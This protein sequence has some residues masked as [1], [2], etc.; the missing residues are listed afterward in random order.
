M[1]ISTRSR[2]ICSTSRPTY[3]TSVNLVASTLMK[4]APASLARRREISVLPTPVGPIIR[5][6]FGSTSSRSFSSSCR[7]RHRLRNATAT[8][9][10]AS[11]CPMM[12]RS[13][14]ETISRGEKSVM[15]S[16]L[17]QGNVAIVVDAN[18]CGN[19]HGFAHDRLCI[20]RP[21]EQS[22]R[23][24][25][26]VIAARAYAHNAALGLEDVA[27][28][29]ENKR[30]LGIRHDH[31]GLQP[32]QIAIGTP[33]LGELDGGAGELPGILLELG[34]K[35]LEQGESIGGSA[36]EAADHITLAEAA[37]LLGICLDHGLPNR[38]LAVA[39]DHDAALLADGEDG[40]AVPVIGRRR[41]HARSGACEACR[42]CAAKVQFGGERE[43]RAADAPDKRRAFP[44]ETACAKGW[45]SAR[46]RRPRSRSRLIST[47]AAHRPSRRGSG[48]SI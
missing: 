27:R 31:H 21:I 2:T 34:L 14:S 36:G 13:S 23:R 26:G 45:S 8:A 39:A 15:N 20:E 28:A 30:H 12:K 40:G 4:G 48:S 11:D 32:A 38:D 18:I 24:R 16:K 44:A 46:P 35:P 41:L 9:R 17:L 7:R 6:F 37:D 47:A 19:V 1:A 22:P 33:V 10:L 42:H 25:E 3:P 29:G 5:I 43:W